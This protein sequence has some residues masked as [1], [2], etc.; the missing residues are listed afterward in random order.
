MDNDLSLMA[1]NIRAGILELSHCGRSAHI[2][3]CLSVADILAAVYGGAMKIAP[4]NV[5]HPDRDRV[6]FGKGHAAA[7]LLSALAEYGFISRETLFREF[8]Q[9][10]GSLQE[11]P[12]P[13]WP[14]GVETAAGSLG[15]AL[16]IAVGLAMAAGIQK[17]EYRVCAIMGD[18]E[19]NE[20]SVWEAAMFAGGQGK[21][22]ANLAAVVDANQWQAIDRS[23]EVTALE[24]LP[25]KWRAFGW[26][27]EEVDG[28]NLDVLYGI[29]RGFGNGT[30]PT[31]I[32]ARTIKGKGVSFMEDDNNWHYRLL[33]DEE[34]ARAKQELTE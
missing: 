32:I 6:V 11:H 19:C 1:R 21:Q 18:G 23:A 5:E 13:D 28:H 25:D 30:K 34:L 24:P 33:K 15:H 16:P 12:G 10:G 9:P 29:L 26:H 27:V 3:S 14:R 8:N 20:G 4:E 31:A 22:L 17:L 7:A 2:G